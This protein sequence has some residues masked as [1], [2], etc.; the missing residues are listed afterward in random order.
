[1]LFNILEFIHLLI[2]VF[3]IAT[4][5]IKKR[6]LNIFTEISGKFNLHYGRNPKCVI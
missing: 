6:K 2:S 4:F 1:M 5:V 3:V